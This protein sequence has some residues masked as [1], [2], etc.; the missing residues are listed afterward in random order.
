MF[1]EFAG[2]RFFLQQAITPVWMNIRQCLVTLVLRSEDLSADPRICTWILHERC[3]LA[4]Q[5]VGRW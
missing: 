3:I 2:L 4:S 1:L 5:L